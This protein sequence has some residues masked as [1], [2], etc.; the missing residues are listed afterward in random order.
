MRQLET[1]N[2]SRYRSLM[3]EFVI[4]SVI[5]VTIAS[6]FGGLY[7]ISHGGSKHDPAPQASAA[8][9]QRSQNP[10]TLQ[11]KTPQQLE[12]ERSATMQEAK[13]RETIALQQKAIQAQQA[14]QTSQQREQEQFAKMRELIAAKL[15]QT[16]NDAGYDIVVGAV[17][18]T[19]LL[20]GDVY[21]D[22]TTRADSLQMLRSIANDRLCP[23]GFR[24][25][26]IGT[27]LFSIDHTYSLH[28]SA[29]EN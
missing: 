12:Q 11:Q 13:M 19:L 27:G 3:K 29:G 18:P 20:H 16:L 9:S 15:H 4:E 25:V 24:T 22:T 10:I 7:Y 26:A 21:T 8:D 5:I 28:C 1:T 6:A 17:G 23:W 14:A 2:K